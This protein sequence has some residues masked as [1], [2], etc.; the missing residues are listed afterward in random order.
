MTKRL[1]ADWRG[2]RDF[3]PM[4]VARTKVEFD[5]VF[6]VGPTTHKLLD[7]WLSIMQS[8]AVDFESEFCDGGCFRH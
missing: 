3:G 8:F 7:E 6:Y 2:Y 4:G 5:L 1:R